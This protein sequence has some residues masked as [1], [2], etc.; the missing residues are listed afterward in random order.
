MSYSFSNPCFNCA[1]KDTCT[2]HKD[3]QAA[4]TT[5]HTKTPEKGHQGSGTIVLMC[6]RVQAQ[7]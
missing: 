6:T 3:I 5:I 2:D 7:S 1:K 4:I